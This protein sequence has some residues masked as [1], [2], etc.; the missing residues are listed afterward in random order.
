MLQSILT[1]LNNASEL[2][3]QF[4]SAKPEPMVILDD[5]LPVQAAENLFVE[6]QHLPNEYWTEF[7]RNKSYMKE[8]VKLNVMPEATNLVSALHSS[9]FITFLE[10]I[11]GINGLIPDP[12]IVGGGYSKSYAGDSLKVHTDFNWN[13]RLKL[14]RALS[15]IIYLTP[16]WDPKWG[17]SLDF[18]DRNNTQ[19]INS[20]DCIF[21]RAVIWKYHKRG[22]H[23]YSKPL[24]CPENVARTTFRVFYYISKT[25]YDEDDRPHRSLYWYDNEL[26]EPYDIPTKK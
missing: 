18:Y 25:P 23:G 8:C 2:A 15:F 10:N 19:I 4:E 26:N 3:D 5:F 6:S 14:H 20:V 9:Q 24:K 11:S 12:H 16:D 7:T 17:G 13:D 1:N 22:F 21:N